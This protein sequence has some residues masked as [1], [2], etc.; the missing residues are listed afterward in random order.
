MLPENEKK[1]WE[2]FEIVVHHICA[3]D[4][5]LWLYAWISSKISEEPEIYQ[6]EFYAIFVSF[7][8]T[9]CCIV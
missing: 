4:G 6:K 9:L 1:I 3:N 2:D 7:I 5:K 8:L